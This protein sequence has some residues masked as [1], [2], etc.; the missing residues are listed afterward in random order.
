MAK[1]DDEFFDDMFAIEL[2]EAYQSGGAE[3]VAR[4]ATGRFVEF[5][6]WERSIDPTRHALERFAERAA[7]PAVDDAYLR[8][9]LRDLAVAEGWISDTPPAWSRLAHTA[10]L[11]LVIGRFLCLPLQPNLNRWRTGVFEPTTTVAEYTDVGW[12]QALE[13]GCVRLPPPP[14]PPRPPDDHAYTAARTALHR[15]A[16][17]FTEPDPPRPRGLPLTPARSQ[18]LA[19]WRDQRDK[20]RADVE[21]RRSIWLN[22]HLAELDR[23]QAHGRDHLAHWERDLVP[24]YQRAWQDAYAQARAG[25]GWLDPAQAAATTSVRRGHLPIQPPRST[26][27]Y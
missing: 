27:P 8:W 2:A 7:P 18:A 21:R 23:N 16:A 24:N 14:P 19:A 17:T 11:Y 22:Y 15:Q 12:E 20:H 26:V 10:R 5:G 6:F 3:R 25:H 9:A 1:E 4:D 13:L